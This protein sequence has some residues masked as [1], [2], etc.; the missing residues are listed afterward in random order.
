MFVFKKAGDVKEIG[1]IPVGH[2]LKVDYGEPYKNSSFA[3][4][5]CPTCGMLGSL[6]HGTHEVAAGG[7]LHPSLVCQQHPGHGKPQCTFHDMCQLEGW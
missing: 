6:A 4:V 5:R 1:D 7:V 2:W 3:V